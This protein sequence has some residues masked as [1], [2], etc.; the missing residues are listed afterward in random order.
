MDCSEESGTNFFPVGDNIVHSL[1]GVDLDKGFFGFL[2]GHRNVDELFNALKLVLGVGAKILVV[3]MNSIDPRV[4]SDAVKDSIS[5]VIPAKAPLPVV[6]WNFNLSLSPLGFVAYE[7]VD[8][9]ARLFAF[10]HVVDGSALAK[11]VFTTESDNCYVVLDKPLDCGILVGLV[12]LH[13]LLGHPLEADV[14]LPW[15]I[16]RLL[17]EGIKKIR[18]RSSLKGVL[19]L[20]KHRVN[21][22]VF[23][24]GLEAEFVCKALVKM[25][26]DLRVRLKDGSEPG[27]TR[28]G[29]GHD[30]ELFDLS[31]S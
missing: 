6:K 4:H 11:L 29:S 12:L 7:F 26:E 10:L 13:E 25:E 3:N 1:S 16:L 5:H 14:R 20:H 18:H 23:D 27:R 17:V 30:N 2:D 31:V 19:S 28:S 9:L 22:P 24:A 15:Q 21:I 8:S